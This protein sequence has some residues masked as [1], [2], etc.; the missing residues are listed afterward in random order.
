LFWSSPLS[1]TPNAYAQKFFFM[2]YPI[3]SGNDGGNSVPSLTPVITALDAVI[4]AADLPHGLGHVKP[5]F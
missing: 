3:K 2:D 1:E 5:L 4:H